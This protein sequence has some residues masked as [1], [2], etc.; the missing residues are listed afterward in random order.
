MN[1]AADLQ[2]VCDFWGVAHAV[3]IVD[4]KFEENLEI[5]LEKRVAGSIIFLVLGI[6]IL[7]ILQNL[8]LFFFRSYELSYL[9]FALLSLTVMAWTCHSLSGK[10]SLDLIFDSVFSFLG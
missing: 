9:I 3:I 8:A 7:L 10:A 1:V 6:L 2:W 5:P 4:T